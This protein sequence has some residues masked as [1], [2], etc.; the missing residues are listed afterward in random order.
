VRIPSHADQDSDAMPIAIP[1]SCRSRFRRHADQGSELMP[2]K[3]MTGVFGPVIG[4][5]TKLATM[6]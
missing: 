1:R 3:K 6:D 4:V 2:I 5:G